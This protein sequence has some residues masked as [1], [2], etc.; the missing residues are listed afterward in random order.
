MYKANKLTWPALLS[1]D[2]AGNIL[3]FWKKLRLMPKKEKNQIKKALFIRLEHIGDMIMTTPAFEVFKKNNP[4]CK[5]HVLCKN[6]TKQLIKNNPYVDKI[7]TYDAPW[8]IKRNADKNKK[9]KDI[10]QELK[11]EQY[12][13][14][15]EMHGDP[16]NNYLAFTTGAYSVGY[17]CRGGG[18]F[19]N[20]LKKYDNQKTHNIMQNIIL[21]EDFCKKIR[22]HGFKDAVKKMKIFTDKQSKS[23]CLNIMKKY[24]LQ[25]KKFI[26][27]NPLSGRKEKDLNEEEVIKFIKQNKN[28]KIVFNGSSNECA[29]NKNF[30]KYPNT[31]N[32]TGKLDLLTLTELVKYAKKVYAPDT[33]II[34]IAKSVQTPFHALYKTTNSSVWGYPR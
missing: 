5:V 18:F 8:F 26:I 13:L 2:I 34:H 17:G 31:I 14:V 19:L 25:N 10:V 24:K 20:R 23:A 1:I 3:F 15:F 30:E 33:G 7:I 16:R 4:E 12:D 11:K 28:L 21:I 6:L 27:I 22:V 29:F 9:F 32:L